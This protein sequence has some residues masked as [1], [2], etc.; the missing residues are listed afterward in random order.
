MPTAVQRARACGRGVVGRALFQAWPQAAQ[1]RRWCAAG[2][3]E[4][5]RFCLQGP[6]WAGVGC[7]CDSV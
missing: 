1:E 7:G 4:A 6:E 2:C 5:P 3:F